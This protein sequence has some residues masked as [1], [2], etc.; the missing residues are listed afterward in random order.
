VSEAFRETSA[1]D[2]QRYVVVAVD[3]IHVEAANLQRLKKTLDRFLER[4]VPPEDL[5][6][7]VTTSGARSQDFTSDRRNLRD[8]VA[9]LLVA[10][11]A[12]EANRRPL[13]RRVPGRANPAGDPEAL[14]VAVEEIRARRSSPNMVAEAQGVA[15]MVHAEAVANS[16]NTL[17]TLDNVVRAMA[18]LRGRKVVILVSDGFLPGLQLEG[19]AGFDIR[20]I[21]DAGARSGVIVYGLDSR[22]LQATAQARVP[23]SRAGDGS[24]RRAQQMARA[25]GWRP[26][27]RCLGGDTGGSDRVHQQLPRPAEDHQ[28]R[29]YYLPL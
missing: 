2:T 7:L 12:A 21:T 13:H 19:G 16:R 26:R 3:D 29:A 11:P 22:G 20:R 6:A 27:A 5:V 4:D 10:G 15:R 25:S 1:P 17:E 9:R 14:R 28:G 24:H 23:Q 8:V 18:T